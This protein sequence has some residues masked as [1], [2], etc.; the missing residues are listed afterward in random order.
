MHWKCLLMKWPSTHS[1]SLQVH[2]NLCWFFIW[3][4]KKE[5]IFRLVHVTATVKCPRWHL[6]NL[7]LCRWGTADTSGKRI[8]FWH[9]VIVVVSCFLQDNVN[10]ISMLT[11]DTFKVEPKKEP[12]LYF[13]CTSHDLWLFIFTFIL[14]GAFSTLCHF[15]TSYESDFTSFLFTCSFIIE[16]WKKAWHILSNIN[17][18]DGVHTHT[19]GTWWHKPKTR[20]KVKPMKQTSKLC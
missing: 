5:N 2:W 1:L 11:T 19:L 14:D 20:A 10:E 8:L 12:E 15:L 16:C 13:E 17:W 9:V 7:L 3:C 6:A 18:M 4:R